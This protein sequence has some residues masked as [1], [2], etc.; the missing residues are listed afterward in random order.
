[1]DAK[2]YSKAFEQIIGSIDLSDIP[3]SLVKYGAL[4]G[5]YREL[6]RERDA[7]GFEAF[8]DYAYKCEKLGAA[9]SRVQHALMPLPD[10][11]GPD[12]LLGIASDYVR[13]TKI[14]DP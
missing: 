5:I 2:R 7:E 12:E 4:E 10:D 3:G 8:H 6:L 9:L 14:Q 13:H 11:K 1:M